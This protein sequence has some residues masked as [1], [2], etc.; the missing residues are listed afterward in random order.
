MTKKR[1]RETAGEQALQLGATPAAVMKKWRTLE[2]QAAG[3]P[4]HPKWFQLATHR[5][6]VDLLERK[7]PLRD[8]R[9]CSE[10]DLG[11]MEDVLYHL[12]DV[13]VFLEE[14]D[15]SEMARAII[16]TQ[17]QSILGE[18]IDSSK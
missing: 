10:D 6:V 3:K 2:K 18:E 13:Q 4:S 16:R 7:V 17:V 5:R 15:T 9:Q 1:K 14:S 11:A 8:I 12:D